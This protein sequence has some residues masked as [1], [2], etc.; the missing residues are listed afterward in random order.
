MTSGFYEGPMKAKVLECAIVITDKDL[1]ELATGHWVIGGYSKEDPEALPDFHQ[2]FFRDAEDGGEFPPLPDTPG[3]GLFSR[4]LAS[5]KAKDEVEK[6]MIKLIL[7]HCPAKGCPLAGN[8][9]QCD[10]EVLCHEMPTFVSNLNHQIIDVST[11]IG[12]ARRWLPWKE[13]EWKDDQKAHA[14]YDHSAVND[15]RA[16]IQSLRWIREHLLVQPHE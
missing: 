2:K 11:F 13:D 7:E 4:V 9:I 6:E 10:R 1:H 12:V 14:T 5:T 8:S 16:S 3:N 15:V